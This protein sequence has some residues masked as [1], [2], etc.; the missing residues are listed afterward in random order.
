MKREI[1]SILVLLLCLCL[2]TAAPVAAL[3]EGDF[4]LA[5]SAYGVSAAEEIRMGTALASLVENA[6]AEGEDV[7]IWGM[8]ELLAGAEFK[9]MQD[10]RP[11]E[12]AFAVLKLLGHDEEIENA[13]AELGIEPGEDAQLLFEA[14]T[15]RLGAMGEED[16]TQFEGLLERYFPVYEEEGANFLQV[17]LECEGETNERV[18]MTF[19]QSEAGDWV[20]SQIDT[21]EA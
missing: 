14:L 13:A 10:L 5:S 18:R 17:T 3:A 7:R 1:G 4:V 2:L 6:A 15:E 11:A 8:D 16:W 21:A 9:A 20:L 19:T 12:R